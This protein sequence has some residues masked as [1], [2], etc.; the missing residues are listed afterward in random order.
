MNTIKVLVCLA[1]TLGFV[2]QLTAISTAVD[3]I[4]FYFEKGKSYIE[5]NVSDSVTYCEKA[6]YRLGNDPENYD[7][8]IQFVMLAG[9][10][11][12]GRGQFELSIAMYRKA[13]ELAQKYNDHM[14]AGEM[15][16]EISQAYRIFHNYDQAVKY[17]LKSYQ[18]VLLDSANHPF[19]VVKTLTI[20]GSA[21]TEK[22]SL[23][24]AIFYNFKAVE[25]LSVMDTSVL[26]SPI[27]NLGY[28]L[29]EL[30]RLEE[31]KFWTEIGL[32]HYLPTGDAYSIGSIYTNLGMY[33]NRANKLPYAL[34]MFDSAIHYTSKSQ[35]IETLFW[36]YDERA[37]VYTKM[38]RHDL[39]AKDLKELIEVKDS[40][41]VAQRDITTQE[42]ETRFQTTEK[43]KQ[44]AIQKADI[45]A[46]N[47]ELKF[48]RILI[49]SLIVILFLI[50][51]VVLLI[52]NRMLLK[53][54]RM[55]TEEVNRIKE[56]QI[57]AG[58][59][60]QEKER[61]R[62][63]KDLH[64]NMGQ[65][66]SVMNIS[67]DKL[68]NTSNLEKIEQSKT[69]DLCSDTLDDMYKEVKNVCFDLMPQSLQS[70][71]LI[72]ALKEFCLR[73]NALGKV[74]IELITIGGDEYPAD[75]VT[76]SQFRITQEWINN[77]LKYSDAQHITI[78]VIQDDE[79]ILLM[80]EDDG[81]GF[82]RSLLMNGK[83]NGWR[84]IESRA[85]FV[86]GEIDLDTLP[87]RTGNTFTLTIKKM[88]SLPTE[89]QIDSQQRL[90]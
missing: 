73:I 89:K 70:S 1:F 87:N 60:S 32:R 20:L 81:Q 25:F 29:M 78:Q 64:D 3:S 11:Q 63:A 6:L 2:K 34:E 21:Y 46:K 18:E 17:G 49:V 88:R 90:A 51:L 77:I 8:V 16:I 71:G 61:H 44:I 86:K 9:H 84:N 48:N 85:Q 19:K 39:A 30:G 28:T 23:D 13:R 59:Q 72:I 55:A 5:L 68:K 65:L 4:D 66:I 15:Y 76:V 26:K 35:Y 79:E 58:I 56:A 38:G 52:R 80:I 57:S 37:Q 83:G 36:I 45:H 10:W 50:V 74:K 75:E 7:K 42:M 54:E 24:S 62:F 67:I 31:C 22:G 69:Y 27:V 47:A 43:E 14:L 41:F 33:G 40:V 12:E 82:D 53:Q